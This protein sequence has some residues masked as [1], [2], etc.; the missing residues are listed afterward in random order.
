MKTIVSKGDPTI[1]SNWLLDPS[2]EN[3]YWKYILSNLRCKTPS[4]Q[5]FL[6][7][8]INC[9]LISKDLTFDLEM[10]KKQAASSS[11]CSVACISLNFIPSKY[12]T[13]WLY[14]RMSAFN[15]RILNI[16]NVVTKVQRPCFITW[17]TKRER[18]KKSS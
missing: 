11:P 6:T 8:N 15:A 4:R 2:G 3:V 14:A 12:N 16:C 13:D 1:H 18:E 17:Q 7:W 9:K 5:E 10:N